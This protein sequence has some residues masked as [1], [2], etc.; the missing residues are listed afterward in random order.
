MLQTRLATTADSSLIANHRSA[1]FRA[2]GSAP[3]EVLDEM[4]RAFEPW[5]LRR[6]TEG[7]YMGWITCN[8]DCPIASIGLLLLDW[9][10]HPL[11]PAGAERGY[12]LNLFIEPEYRRRGL[13]RKLVELCLDEGRRRNIGVIS[14][15]A[16]AEGR[17]LYDSLGFQ[18]SNEMQL[19]NRPHPWP[20]RRVP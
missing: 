7:R 11:D 13:A 1:M 9:P 17:P 18:S 8:G 16:S 20:L 5:V 3:P 12:I 4:S 2:M 14:L 19:G 15:H 10:P 6:L